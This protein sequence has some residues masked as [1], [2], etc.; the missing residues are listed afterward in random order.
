MKMKAI[1]ETLCG[2]RQGVSIEAV[3]GDF[4]DIINVEVVF[5]PE[6]EPRLTRRFQFDHVEKCKGYYHEVYGL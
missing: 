1:L 3:D 6:T 2:C 5:E 4:P